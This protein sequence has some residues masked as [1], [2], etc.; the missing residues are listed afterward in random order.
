MAGIGRIGVLTSGGDCAGLNAAIRAVALRAILGYGWRVFGIH[1]GTVG[2]MQRPLGY[3]ELTLGM[4]DGNVL[5]MGGTMLGT[6]NRGDPFAFPMPDGSLKDRS[7]DIAAGY[8][9]LGLDAVIAIGGDGSLA[10]LRRIAAPH[11]MNLVGIPKTID[12][13]VPFTE[14]SIGYV[15]AVDVATEALDR[16]QPTAASHRRVMLLEVMGR[17]NG[18][19]ALN[20]GIAG[21]VDVILIPEIPYSMY[22]IC[23]KLDAVRA[24]GRNFSLMVVAE[25]VLTESGEPVM[26]TDHDGKQRL[27]GIGRYLG[28]RIAEETGAET[29]VTVLG[30]TQRGGTPSARDRIF[31]SAFGVH[32]VDLVAQQKFDRMV[33]WSNRGCIDVPLSDVID[34]NHPVDLNGATV[35]TA[36]GLGICMGD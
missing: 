11:G 12:N 5:R 24:E 15:T 7:A 18:H 29:R 17:E 19:I 6:T 35:H 2:L 34:H 22:A 31:A 9:D 25:G 21:G 30:H 10:I 28:R 13:D 4:F 14:N 32:A 26:V 36:R 23:R 27:G 3:T 33:A 16:L 20:A 8:H 1:E